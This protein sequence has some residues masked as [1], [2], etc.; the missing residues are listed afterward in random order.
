MPPIYITFLN[1][2]DIEE[3][4]LTNDEI[5]GAIDSL[6]RPDLEQK[7]AAGETQQD[8]DGPA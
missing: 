1:R 6:G 2:L 3:L 4:A 7:A 5:L 8:V